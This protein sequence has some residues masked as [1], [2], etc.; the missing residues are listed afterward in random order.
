MLA[1]TPE[2][3]RKGSPNK[4]VIVCVLSTRFDNAG[5]SL[6]TDSAGKLNFS[7]VAE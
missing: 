2:T 6:G 7:V 1:L 3:R 4:I 5:C